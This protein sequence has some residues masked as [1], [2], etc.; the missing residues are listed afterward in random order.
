M[1][2]FAPSKDEPERLSSIQ[3][4]DM[5]LSLMAMLKEIGSSSPTDHSSAEA[6]FTINYMQVKKEVIIAIFDLGSQKNLISVGLVQ[7]LWVGD[8]TVPH[9]RPY[10]LGWITNDVNQQINHQCTIRFAI[11]SR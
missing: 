4:A 9:P 11:S 2:T 3:Q 10:P 7:R 1:A 8:N 5:T 6:L